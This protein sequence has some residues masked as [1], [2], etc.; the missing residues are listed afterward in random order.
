MCGVYV[1]P[2]VPCA[3]FASA[4]M[5]M[6]ETLSLCCFVNW[7][8]LNQ[9]VCGAWKKLASGYDGAP[10]Y[11]DLLPQVVWRGTNFGFLSH[12]TAA[13]PNFMGMKLGQRVP[14]FD[15]DVPEEVR[16]MGDEDD[17]EDVEDEEDDDERGTSEKKKVAATRA[18]KEASEAFWPRWKAVAEVAAKEARRL[19][20]SS[21]VEQVEWRGSDD[22]EE[23]GPPLPWADMRFTKASA[24]SIPQAYDKFAEFGVPAMAESMSLDELAR[25][26]YHVDIGGGGGTTWTGTLEKLSMPGLLF[27]HVTPTKDYIHDRMVPWVHYV[28]IATDLSDLREKYDWAEAHPDAARTIA[29]N[30]SGLV[31]ELSAPEGFG[32]M[33]QEDVVAP[34]RRIIEAYTPVSESHPGV[35]WREVVRASEKGEF[36]RMR[37]KGWSPSKGKCYR[38]GEL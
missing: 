23:E 37:C 19:R 1:M 18:M 2:I 14:T 13:H 5:P 4:A 17:D 12:I 21:E 26:K 10:S 35:A 34:L 15:A 8:W 7:T 28:P 3:P 33:Y 22:E 6:P 16:A 9:R 36:V 30:G 29:E 24:A 32:R 11:E 25:F 20:A 38:G 27:H 31:R